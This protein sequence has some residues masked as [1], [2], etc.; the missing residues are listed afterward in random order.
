MKSLRGM[1]SEYSRSLSVS[2]TGT[3]FTPSAAALSAYHDSSSFAL[4]SRAASRVADSRFTVAATPASFVSA[5]TDSTPPSRG[6][7]RRVTLVCAALNWSG[8]F[9]RVVAE[10]PHRLPCHLGHPLLAVGG[11]LERQV[12]RLSGPAVAR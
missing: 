1:S 5:C 10:Q 6:W 2:V 4:V 12:A 7:R 3:G 8:E 11:R 9:R